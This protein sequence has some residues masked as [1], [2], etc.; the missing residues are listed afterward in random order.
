[1][2][3]QKIF[4]VHMDFGTPCLDMLSYNPRPVWTTYRQNYNISKYS[5]AQRSCFTDG[6]NHAQCHIT[7]STNYIWFMFELHLVLDNLK[8]KIY[9]SVAIHAVIVELQ[10]C[11][12][13]PQVHSVD[14]TSKIWDAHHTHLHSTRNLCCISPIFTRKYF[15]IYIS[16]AAG[17]YLINK[18]DSSELGIKKEMISHLLMIDVC[19]S[20]KDFIFPSY[21][22]QLESLDHSG[23]KVQTIEIY[24]CPSC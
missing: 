22:T 2:Q 4:R 14:Q 16:S 3:L 15:K 13:S 19:H 21:R 24:A 20:K 23:D 8:H 12:T 7:D 17:K 5:G 11:L 10:Y 1:M 6:I 18:L 9:N